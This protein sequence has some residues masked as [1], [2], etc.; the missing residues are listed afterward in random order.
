[1]NEEHYPGVCYA[2]KKETQ[3]RWKNLY[4]IGSEGTDLC[5]L[6]EMVVVNLLRTMARETIIKRVQTIKQMKGGDLDDTRTKK[7]N[8]AT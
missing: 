6:C 3:V 4:T 8:A 1:M 2:C 5:M 7:D